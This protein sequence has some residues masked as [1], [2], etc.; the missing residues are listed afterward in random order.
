MGLWRNLGV[1][2]IS[3]RWFAWLSLREGH[4]TLGD[5]ISSSSGTQRLHWV[6]GN[7]V[8]QVKT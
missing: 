6:K 4:N 3:H 7:S 5:F 1:I 8:S 2:H